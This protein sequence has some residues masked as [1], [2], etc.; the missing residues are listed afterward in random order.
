MNT[1]A[2][3]ILIVDDEPRN[4]KLLAALLAPEGYRTREADDGEQAL[5]SIAAHAPDLILMDV[6]MPGMDGVELTLLLKADTATRNIP[7]IMISADVDRTA[8][9]AGLD[10]GAEEFLT[11]PVDRAEL[12]LR[13]RNLL[14]LKTLGDHFRAHG[15]VLEEQAHA[16]A[17]DLMHATSRSADL[18]Q[19][20]K[21][22]NTA[23]QA[24]SGFL[25]AM[26]HEIRTPM[27]GV[28]G[29]IDVLQQTDLSAHQLEMVELIRVS[30]FSLLGIIE[31]ILDFSKI[32]AGRLEIEKAPLSLTDVAEGAC[33]ML[34]QLASNKEVEFTLYVDPQ[35]PPTVVGDALRLRQVMLNLVGNA[36]KFS[37][38]LD[39]A[40][41]VCVQLVPVAWRDDEVT[42]EL[43]V[44][45]NGIGVDA[46]TQAR[47]FS[48][49]AQADASTTRRYGGTGLGLVISRRLIDLMGGSLILHSVPGQGATFSARLP[50][51]LA[52]GAPVPPPQESAA[53][54]AG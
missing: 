43:Q 25:A 5:A 24:K 17:A 30:A 16:R 53:A 33:G 8:R 18:E 37:S 13:V 35:L 1:S 22:S 21:A 6:M 3:T 31:D 34:D 32:E 4:R 29:M 42:V 26:S 20:S 19:A 41:R 2:A 39:Y 36:I 14:R 38:G 45:D 44:R 48:S 28:I 15:L 51:A 7:I 54:A 23:N 52:G 49:F 10:A 40:G 27:N 9:L 12:W 50:F 11:K 46:A 47:L